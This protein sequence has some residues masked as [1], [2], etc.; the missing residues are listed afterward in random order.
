MDT[1]D[2][3]LGVSVSTERMSTL[4]ITPHVERGTW[5]YTIGPP[6]AGAQ[7]AVGTG[8]RDRD[9]SAALHGLADPRLTGMG[10]DDLRSWPPTWLPHKQRGPNNATSSNAV[11]DVARSREVTAGLCSPTPTG[12]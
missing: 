9:R 6:A 3:P 2:Y 4:P 5:N 12:S 8:D 1:G 10:R 11:A 7:A